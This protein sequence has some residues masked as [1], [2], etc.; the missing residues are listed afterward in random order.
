MSKALLIAIYFY[1]SAKRKKIEHI[2]SH[3]ASH[4]TDVALFLSK[5]SGLPFSFSCHAHD[6]Y[7][8]SEGLKEKIAAA[9]FVIT[10]T[11]NNKRYL[12]TLTMPSP[13]KVYLVYHGISLKLWPF[14]PRIIAEEECLRVLCVARLVE[15][16][17][18]IYLLEAVKM[19][20]D[21]IKIHCTIV[22]EG[23]QAPTLLEFINR[24]NLEEFIT[25][26]GALSQSK[27]KQMY[28]EQHI[29]ILPS[30]LASDGDRDGI[31]NVLYEAMASGI[32]VISTSTRAIEELVEH[33]KS[34]WLIPE[35][36]SIEIAKAVQELKTNS[37][38][39]EE[40]QMN[41]YSRVCQ[42]NI[43]KST[44]QLKKIFAPTS[45]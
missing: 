16:K 28:K 45:E 5:L 1:P 34:G 12:D 44:E 40:L 26:A 31:P 33:K 24:Y 39:Y 9:S 15:K 18:L 17:G 42:F 23:P 14:I 35:K 21:Q 8:K 36:K 30:V 37:S 27:V 43:T 2:H 10:C 38:L 13:S 19:L 4:P 20:K 3:F 41:A 7:V 32:P 29:F 6:I 25:L 22:G 11:L